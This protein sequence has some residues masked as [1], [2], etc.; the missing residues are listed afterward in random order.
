MKAAIPWYARI[1]AKLLLSRL[2]IPYQAW[3]KAGLFRHGSMHESEYAF[4]VFRQHWEPS[5]LVLRPGFVMMELGPGDSL[6]TALLGAAHGAQRTY[7]IDVG[8][9]AT[10]HLA[11]YRAMA[12]FLVEKQD[13]RVPDAVSNAANLTEILRACNAVYGTR[14][15]PDLREVPDESVDFVWSQAV[16]EHIRRSEFHDLVKNL[17]RILRQGGISSHRVDLKD[18]LGGRLNNLRI[19]A[20]HWE[21]DWM[22]KS[23]FYTNRLRYSEMLRI[24]ANSGFNVDVTH[25]TRWDELPTP[26][27]AMAA[28]FQHLGRDELLIQDFDVM[29]RP[30]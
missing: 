24:F 5:K 8:R 4:S 26:R 29:L 30:I 6:L 11:P 20:R 14:G 1:A 23:G 25:V 10:E 13:M 12:R 19:P 28:E 9:F 3:R 16:L 15:L 21:A 18:H 22:A 7:L 2:P 27:R 17:R